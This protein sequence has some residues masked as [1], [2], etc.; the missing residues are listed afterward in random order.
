MY[1]FATLIPVL[2]PT[3]DE[4]AQLAIKPAPYFASLK[5]TTNSFYLLEYAF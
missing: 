3:A 5:V 4:I 2:M 1:L